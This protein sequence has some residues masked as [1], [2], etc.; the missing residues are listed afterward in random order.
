MLLETR[1]E[2]VETLLEPTQQEL[3]VL[4][5]EEA[6]FSNTVDVGQFFRTRAVMLVEEALRRVASF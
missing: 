6:G 3:V 4:A 1:K 5:S 2:H